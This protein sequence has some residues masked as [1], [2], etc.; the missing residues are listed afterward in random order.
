MLDRSTPFGRRVAHR[1]E[2][3]RIAWLVTVD[4]GGSPQP[5]PIW[6]YW[7]GEALL[8][9]SRPGTAKLVHLRRSPKAAV[10]FNSDGQGGEIVVMVGEAAIESGPLPTEIVS[11][12]LDKYRDGLGRIG[13]TAE[14]FVEAYSVPILFRPFSLRGH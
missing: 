6:F 3:D 1:L 11:A 7:D 12:Y 13:M 2:Q 5:R 14:E 4:R 9:F 8:I 10:H